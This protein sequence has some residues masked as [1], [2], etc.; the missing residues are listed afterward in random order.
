M[1]NRYLSKIS[2]NHTRSSVAPMTR[3]TQTVKRTPS[4]GLALI[5]V[6]GSPT[7]LPGRGDR[8]R[9]TSSSEG[10]EERGAGGEA[11]CDSFHSSACWIVISTQGFWH[12][13]LGSVPARQCVCF[14]S[15]SGPAKVSQRAA[16]NLIK[17]K[18][19]RKKKSQRKSP[20]LLREQVGMKPSCSPSSLLRGGE[21]R[22]SGP[23]GL[24]GGVHTASLRGVRPDCA[25]QTAAAALL[26]VF[27]PI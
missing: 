4:P 21:G 20:Q 18:F 26:L 27:L 6:P 25:H 14:S 5:P 19:R 10:V 24:R 12:C 7:E 23:G 16:K 11:G 15:S 8:G 22:G 1:R 13:G 3:T 17:K 2:C 9:E